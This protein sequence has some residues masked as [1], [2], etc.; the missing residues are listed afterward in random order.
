MNKL[1][2]ELRGVLDKY[3][4][5]EPEYDY[6]GF[7]DLTERLFSNGFGSSNPVIDLVVMNVKWREVIINNVMSH[8]ENIDEAYSMLTNVETPHGIITKVAFWDREKTIKYK[9]R[10]VE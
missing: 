7:I 5:V 6:S 3:E 4:R 9:I 10:E 8:I 1:I 2:K